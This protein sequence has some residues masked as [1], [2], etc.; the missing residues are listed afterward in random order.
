MSSDQGTRGPGRPACLIDG[1][2]K[3]L[4]RARVTAEAYLM[5]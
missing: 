3:K 5:S 4:H 1:Y 2:S